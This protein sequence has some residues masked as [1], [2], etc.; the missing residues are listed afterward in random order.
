MYI[1][2]IP[3]LDA[4]TILCSDLF[5]EILEEEDEVLKARILLAVQEKAK[6]LGKKSEFEMLFKA[7]VKQRKKYD[8]ENRQSEPNLNEV[9]TDGLTHFKGGKYQ[10]YKC[11]IWLANDNGVRTFTMFGENVACTHPILPVQILINAETGLCKVKLAFKVRNK[12]NE[13]IVD[14]EVISSSS[15]IVSLSKYSIRVTSEN[16]KY[17]VQYLSD[18]ESLN[19]DSIVEQVTTSKLGWIRNEFMPYGKNIIFDNEQSFKTVFNSIKECGNREIWYKIAN[20]IRSSGRFEPYINLIAS[21]SSPIVEMVNGLPFI[22]DTYGKTGSGKTVS[23]MLASSVWANPS[24]NEYITD[25]KATVTALELR[26]DFLNNLPILIDD[27]AQLKNKYDGD[28]SELVYFLCSGKGKDRANQNLGINKS[29]TWKNVMLVNSEHSMVTET[30]QGGAINRIIDVEAKPGAFFENGNYV[31]EILKENYG[32]CGKEF[33]ELLKELG[34]DKVREIQKDFSSKIVECAKL[35]GVEKEEKQIIPMSILLTADKLATDY[36]FLDGKYL[37]LDHCVSLLKSK[38]EV[39]EDERAYEYI[40]S[41]VAININKFKP[42]SR[43]EYKGDCWGLTEDGYVI[44][45]MNVFNNFA[46]RGNFSSI[47]FLS[48]AKEKGLLQL[49][50]DGKSSKTKR[51]DGSVSR[52]VYLKMPSEVIINEDGFMEIDEKMQEKLPFD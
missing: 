17:L 52:C 51:L 1:E 3:G 18:I 30:M 45:M 32:F 48:W 47:G 34:V 5:L 11:G 43:G 20:E 14:K 28:F 50:S 24:D 10:D 46:K 29:T 40:M 36:L 13:V 35:L 8:L 42:D 39:S 44:I 37:E 6:L 27:M 41:E 12:W 19:E 2:N 21:L 25:P 33:V 4:N 23:L 7:Y 15:R 31:V 38:G 26:L 16:A 49:S 9:Q 22:V